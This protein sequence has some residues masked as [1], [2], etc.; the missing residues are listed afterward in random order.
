MTDRRDSR[1]SMEARGEE[2]KQP[3]LSAEVP[4]EASRDDTQDVDDGYGSYHDH[5]FSDP[6]IAEY[7][8]SVYA[9]AQYEGRHRFDPDFTWSA[10]EE[11]RLKRKVQAN[12]SSRYLS[13][14]DLI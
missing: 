11:K 3:A 12:Q 10:A 1:S 2:P 5:V 13:R 6:K 4:V 7:W 14:F 9:N 8:R